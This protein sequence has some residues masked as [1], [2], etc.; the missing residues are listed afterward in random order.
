MLPK[1]LDL[2]EYRV[3]FG[4]RNVRERAQDIGD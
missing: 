4:S 1:A 3:E 2:L